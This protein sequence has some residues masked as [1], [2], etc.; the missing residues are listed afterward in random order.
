MTNTDEMTTTCC[1][2]P[3]GHEGQGCAS[4]AWECDHNGAGVDIAFYDFSDGD[5]YNLRASEDDPF[6]GLS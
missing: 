4:G 6:V 5:P 2:V 1:D 3:C